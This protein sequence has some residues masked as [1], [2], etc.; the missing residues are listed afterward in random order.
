MYGIVQNRWPGLSR[1]RPVMFDMCCREHGTTS[2][3][4]LLYWTPSRAVKAKSCMR[5]VKRKFCGNGVI[6]R[7]INIVIKCLV[8]LLINVTMYHDVAVACFERMHIWCIFMFGKKYSLCIC[9]CRRMY[10][11]LLVFDYQHDHYHDRVCMYL[12]G[13]WLGMWVYTMLAG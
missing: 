10:N 5:R 11:N 12:C 7:K 1:T 4:V 13:A 8:I 2:W 9:G 6:H 3:R